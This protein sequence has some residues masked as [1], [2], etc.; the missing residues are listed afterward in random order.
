MHKRRL[1]YKKIKIKKKTM[2]FLAYS[3]V[4]VQLKIG[5]R[6]GGGLLRLR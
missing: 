5:L 1:T 6:G 3:K 4:N 2:T